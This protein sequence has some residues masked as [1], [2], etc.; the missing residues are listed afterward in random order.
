MVTISLDSLL[1]GTKH[2]AFTT[3]HVT[4][5]N[6]TKQNYKQKQHKNWTTLHKNC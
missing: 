2:R 4:D 5:K 3:N 6:K 1:T